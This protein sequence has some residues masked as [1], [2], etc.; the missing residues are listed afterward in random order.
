MS[1]LVYTP[2]E[3]AQHFR[4]D[5]RI[6]E[7]LIG[8]GRIPHVRL[9]P[10]KVVIPKVQLEQ[11]LADEAHASTIIWELEHD[12]ADIPGISGRRGVA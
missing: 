5:L 11:W 12:G 2:A 9:S 1:D 3:L 4:C 7:Q 6:V 10:R 8:E